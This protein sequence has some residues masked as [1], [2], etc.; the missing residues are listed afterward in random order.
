MK[1]SP[2]IFALSAAAVLFTAM[3]GLADDSKTAQDAIFESKIRP[4]FVAKCN[5]CHSGEHPMAGLKLDS[6]EDSTRAEPRIFL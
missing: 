3:A 2:P 1:L 4:I 5:S 6:A